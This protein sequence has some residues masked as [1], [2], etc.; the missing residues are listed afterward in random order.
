MT[1]VQVASHPVPE[2]AY[3]NSLAT[4][5][6]QQQQRYAEVR[7]QTFQKYDNETTFRFHETRNTT[8]ALR[9]ETEEKL[10]EELQF[11]MSFHKPPPDFSNKPASVRLNTAAILREE[12]LLR[13]QQARDAELIRAYEVQLRD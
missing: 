8:D 12:A 13:Q 10:A 3:N 2:S 7:T 9:Q 11:S 6:E 4:I 5:E 1:I